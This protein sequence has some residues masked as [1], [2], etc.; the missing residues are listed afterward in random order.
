[1]SQSLVIS[2]RTINDHSVS[3]LTHFDKGERTY[4]FAIPLHF[5]LL[6]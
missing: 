4:M 3:S 5:L 6:N 1:M 2:T